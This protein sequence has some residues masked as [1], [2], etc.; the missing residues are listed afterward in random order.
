MVVSMCLAASWTVAQRPRRGRRQQQQS[1]QA[2]A[3][4]ARQ[5]VTAVSDQLGEDLGTIEWGWTREQF[6]QHFRDT[7]REEYRPRIA[8]APGAIEEDRLRYEMNDRIRSVRESW[9]EFDGRVSG[10]DQ[11][12]LRTEYTH[13]NQEA[14]V[15]MQQP[16]AADDYY[17]FIQ[18]KLWKWYRAF[19]GDTFAGVD[20]DTVAAAFEQRYGPGTRREGQRIEDGPVEQWIEWHDDTTNARVMDTSSYGFY[21]LVLEDRAVASR[22]DSLRPNRRVPPRRLNPLIQAITPEEQ[23]DVHDDN[24]DIVDRLTARTDGGVADAGPA[25]PSTPPPA[26][27]PPANTGMR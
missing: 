8:R 9:F 6:V 27:T 11:S 15:R 20:F 26:N 10:Y 7:L 22:I 17:F 3:Q 5:P 12:F 18:G 14:M 23:G 4:N 2:A 16:L 24:A 21:V 1:Q 19:K 25:R 13:N